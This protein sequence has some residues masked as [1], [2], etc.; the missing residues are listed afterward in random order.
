[1][2]QLCNVSYIAQAESKVGDGELEKWLAKLGQP[3]PGLGLDRRRGPSFVQPQID[4]LMP[5]AM[6]RGA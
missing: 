3:P 5:P 6:P 1:M 2:R 4:M